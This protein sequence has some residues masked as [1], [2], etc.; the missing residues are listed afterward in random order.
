MMI[1]DDDDDDSVCATKAKIQIDDDYR[2]FEGGA[3]ASGRV[4]GTV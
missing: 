3:K 2:M 1:D 4:A